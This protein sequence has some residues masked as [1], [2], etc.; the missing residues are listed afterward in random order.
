MKSVAK[1]FLLLLDGRQCQTLESTQ[2]YTCVHYTLTRPA[3]S[4]VEMSLRSPHSTT[5]AG[6]NLSKPRPPAIA[7]LPHGPFCLSCAHFAEHDA[8]FLLSH[9]LEAFPQNSRQTIQR[10]LGA[11]GTCPEVR[12]TCLLCMSVL[13]INLQ[14]RQNFE[15]FWLTCSQLLLYR[16]R[17]CVGEAEENLIWLAICLTP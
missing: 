2:V 7:F 16:H 17:R 9:I 3:S 13:S 4:H 5:F 8:N 15:S 14:G 10:R 1:K 6:T 11:Q 12:T